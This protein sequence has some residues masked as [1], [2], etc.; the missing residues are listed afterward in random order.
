MDIT[1]F[2]V[3]RRDAALL[4]GDYSTY[5]AQL[6][7]KILKARKRLGIATKNRGKY[8]KKDQFSAEDVGQNREYVGRL[9]LPSI[10]LT[11]SV[12]STDVPIS[13]SSR[14]NVPGPMP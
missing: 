9:P 13:F 8:K 4:Y 11:D 12:L 5:Q 6:G 14:A 1:Q 7:K 10:V 2:V 3:S